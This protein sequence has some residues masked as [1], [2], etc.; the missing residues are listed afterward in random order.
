MGN[1]YEIL[2]EIGSGGMAKVYKAKDRYLQRTIAIKILKDE[3][4]E[5]LE[6]L[7][8]FD[9]EA[10]AAASLTHPNIVQIYDVGRE[11]NRYYIVMEYVDGITLKE[12]IQ[13]KGYLEWR[14]AINIAIQICSALAKAHSRHIIHRDI[15]PNNIIMTSDKVPKITDFG[16]AR[17]ASSET[18]TMKIDTIGSVHYSS[19]EQVR[20][21]YTDEQSDIYSIGVTIFEMV[22][23]KLPFDGETSVAVALKHIQEEPPIPSSIKPGLPRALDG[24]ILKAMA[25]NKQD[26]YQT[27]NELISDLEN[28]RSRTGASSEVIL[29][30]IKRDDMFTTRKFEPIGDEDLPKGQ[31][32]KNKETSKNGNGNNK[33]LMPILYVT[34]IVAILGSIGIFVKTLL[35]ELVTPPEERPKEII[36]GNYVNRDINDVLRELEEQGISP[37]IKYE[38]D[39]IVAENMVMN[40]EPLPDTPFKVGG[41]TKLVL[42]VSKGPKM[43]EIPNVLNQD[44]NTVKFLLEDEYGLKVKEVS[45]YNEEVGINLVIKTDPQPGTEVKAGSEVTVYWSMGPEKKPVVVPNLVG[46]TYEQAVKKLRDS[47]LKLGDVFP[48]GREG[49]TGRIVDQAPKAGETVPEDT[50]I[51]IYFEE[52]ATET[53]GDPSQAGGHKTVTINLPNKKNWGDV[54]RLRVF[55]M[56]MD[57]GDEIELRDEMISTSEF[58]VHVAVPI[59]ASGGV[60]VRVYINDTLVREET[61]NN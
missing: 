49:Y 55:E 38:N 43:V 5:D 45:E 18:A 21:G 50:A 25:K 28:I 58:P 32:R 11:N 3:F 39:D 53:H 54:V 52:E 34:L 57:T 13:L 29:P 12:Y 19:P 61:F 42:T 23:G 30:N 48:E 6:F 14:E 26:R 40:Q 7:K 20:G 44:H 8:R 47:S 24:I 16:I 51:T 36:L 33:Y 37:E 46:D 60:M 15:K 22:T 1:R 10:Q 27:V 2:S 41:I 17:L 31:R 35:G 9:T 4:S 56:L 59:P